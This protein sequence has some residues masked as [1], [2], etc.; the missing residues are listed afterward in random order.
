MLSSGSEVQVCVKGTM[1]DEAY[2]IEAALSFFLNVCSGVKLFLYGR[3]PSVWVHC[4]SCLCD[5]V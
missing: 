1:L 5:L 3:C 4:Q 2:P